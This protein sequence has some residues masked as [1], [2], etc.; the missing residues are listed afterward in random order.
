MKS[1]PKSLS[2]SLVKS[3]TKSK[4]EIHSDFEA[5]EMDETLYRWLANGISPA[6]RESFEK[7]MLYNKRFRE[8]FCEWIKA[9][10]EPA[11]ALSHTKSKD[12]GGGGNG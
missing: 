7:T 5:Q 3:L 12:S 11:W 10:R 9:I 8:H 2:K 6:E 1:K 4:S